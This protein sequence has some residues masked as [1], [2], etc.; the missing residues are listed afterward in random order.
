MRWIKSI[1]T[2][3]ALW[4]TA[5][6]LLFLAAFSGFIYL[7]LNLSL[8]AAMDDSLSLGAEQVAAGLNVD[9]GQILIPE[10]I[11]S[12]ET[13]YEA[14]AERGLVLL[15]LSK[16]GDILEATGPYRAFDVP[17]A[18]LDQQPR[19]LTQPEVNGT[20][21]LRIY[22]LPVMDNGRLVGW[23]LTLKSM[24][25]V[26]ESLRRLLN[27]LLLGGTSLLLLAGFAGYFLA[28]RALAPIDEIGRAA[29]RIT[30]EDLSA[31]LPLPPTGD[32]IERLTAAFNDML[33]RIERGFRRERQ[34]TAD[35]SHELRTPLA[36][37]QAILSVTR[38]RRRDPEEY[39]Q[40]LDDLAEETERLQNLTDSLLTLARADLVAFEAKAPIDL[41]TLL[42]DVT[43][44]MRPLAEVKGLELI[45][46]TEANLTIQ[47]DGDGLIRLFVN[48]LDNAIKYTDT[49]RVVVS[50]H[51]AGDKVQ[52]EVSDSGAG[53]P[54]TQLARIFERFYRV[55][56][57]RSS[58]GAGLGLAIARQV[59]RAH[60]GEIDVD[61]ASGGGST[62][63]VTLPR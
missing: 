55:D 19:Y 46:D 54:P 53:I 3:F 63:H 51:S 42:P 28:A 8:R 12:G 27:A 10:A 40:A 25:D 17:T 2:R 62:F 38:Q 47:G 44:S 60:G 11:T 15:I 58:S 22:S 35:A 5:L 4:A 33:A 57:A 45:C 18:D 30:V 61:S 50:A 43:E 31:R 20:N 41:S 48:L 37:M 21:P 24:G 34:F 6:I 32:E 26:Q 29:R 1:R 23:V 36:A 7:N 14:Y 9:N 59:V 39:E 52:I 49:G 56:P 13:G 16:S